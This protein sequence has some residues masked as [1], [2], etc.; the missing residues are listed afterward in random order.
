MLRSIRIVY[1]R[2][3][4]VVQGDAT[5]EAAYHRGLSRLTDIFKDCL[6]ENVEDRMRAG[7]WRRALRSARLLARESPRRLVTA[8]A[9]GLRAAVR[10]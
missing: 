4:P 5:G 7:E 2:Q 3:W 6:V 1:E 9:R 8:A 10:R